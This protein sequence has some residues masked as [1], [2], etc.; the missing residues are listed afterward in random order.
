MSKR[1]GLKDTLKTNYVVSLLVLT[2]LFAGASAVL[3]AWP[4]LAYLASRFF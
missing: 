3:V 1:N 4:A 2:G